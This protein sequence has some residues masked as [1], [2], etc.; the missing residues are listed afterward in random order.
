MLDRRGH[1]SPAWSR[2]FAQPAIGVEGEGDGGAGAD[3][4]WSP[5]TDGVTPIP[6]LLYD[7]NGDV[8]MGFVTP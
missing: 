5:I 4:Y 2:Y 8:V 3:G 7:S 6:E 1:V